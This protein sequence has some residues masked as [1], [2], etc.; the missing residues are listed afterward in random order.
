MN[1]WC[2]QHDWFAVIDLKDAYSSHVSTFPQHRPFL[3]FAF[4]NQ[5]YK[6]KVLPFELPLSPR[7]IPKVPEATLASLSKVGIFNY[8]SG[9]LAG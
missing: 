1:A 4:E 2:H 5:A 3:Q 9:W 7:V 8:L 6:F